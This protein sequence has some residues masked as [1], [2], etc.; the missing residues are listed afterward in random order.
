VSHDVMQVGLSFLCIKDDHELLIS[1]PALL[2]GSQVC[3]VSWVS[4]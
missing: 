3:S 1:L 2:L 4:A